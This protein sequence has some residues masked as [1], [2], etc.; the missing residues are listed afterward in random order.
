VV[1]GLGV[2]TTNDAYR[3]YRGRAAYGPARARQIHRTAGHLS[4][5]AM[6]FL[7]AAQVAARGARAD[8]RSRVAKLLEANQRQ[9]FDEAMRGLDARDLAR[10]LL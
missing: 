4:M 6:C 1:L 8:E 7:L 9:A 10:R 3:F 5:D 2:L